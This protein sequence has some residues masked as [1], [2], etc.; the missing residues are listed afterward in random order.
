MELWRLRNPEI[1]LYH[2]YKCGREGRDVRDWKTVRIEK[3]L[4]GG[5]KQEFVRDMCPQ[6]F[7]S[8]IVRKLK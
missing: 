1:A 4:Q 7:E 2:C 3:T 5:F 6:C 8:L